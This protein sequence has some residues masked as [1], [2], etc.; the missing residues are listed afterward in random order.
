MTS[1]STFTSC[2]TP[3]TCTR[4]GIKAGPFARFFIAWHEGNEHRICH[5]CLRPDDTDFGWDTAREITADHRG[6]LTLHEPTS[7]LQ[8]TDLELATLAVIFTEALHAEDPTNEMLRG[9]TESIV[10]LGAK[11]NRAMQS[12]GFLEEPEVEREF[13]ETSRD[14]VRQFQRDCRARTRPTF[15]AIDEGVA[16]RLRKILEMGV[17]IVSWADEE[18]WSSPLGHDEE[19]LHQSAQAFQKDVRTILEALDEKERHAQDPL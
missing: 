2:A 7:V 4:C 13:A 18:H 5:S 9:E 19:E 3:L 8:L 17:S 16:K 15:F 11:L 12:R 14:R 10:A 1:P 6:Q